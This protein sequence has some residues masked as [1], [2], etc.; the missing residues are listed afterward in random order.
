MKFSWHILLNRNTQA[1]E[2]FYNSDNRT[3]NHFGWEK[4]NNKEKLRITDD[5]K[6]RGFKRTLVFWFGTERIGVISGVRAIYI[7][8]IKTVY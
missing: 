3:E 8:I 6:S 7:C 4:K 2:T 1:A 5:V